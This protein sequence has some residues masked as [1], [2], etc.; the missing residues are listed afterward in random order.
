MGDQGRKG[1]DSYYT[2]VPAS[3]RP[4]KPK[5]GKA[6]PR[7]RTE[8]R[9]TYNEGKHQ[10][11]G[12]LRGKGAQEVSADLMARVVR[13][14]QAFTLK[15][16]G[17]SYDQIAEQLKVS[18]RTAY[19]DVHETAGDFDKVSAEM[20]PHFR[21]I[22]EARLDAA[23]RHIWPILQGLVNPHI[24]PAQRA[25][26]QL[27]AADRVAR[28]SARRAALLGLDAPVKIA[29]TNPEGTRPFKGLTDEELDAQMAQLAAESGTPLRLDPRKIIDTS[30]IAGNGNGHGDDH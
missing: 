11:T 24:T 29:P 9:E 6:T 30:A 18:V 15:V 3:M 13:R 22:E 2:T 12:P 14:L 27:A 5:R 17:F 25:A 23:L 1:A 4:A 10:N 16:A 19:M 7:V 8:A 28:V 26:L 20:V 21:A